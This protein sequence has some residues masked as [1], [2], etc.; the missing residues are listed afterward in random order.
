MPVLN[1]RELTMATA[2]DMKA[3]PVRKVSILCSAHP[4]WG[5]FGVM[6][7]KGDW[8]DIFGRGGWRV[9]FKDEAERFWEVKG[10]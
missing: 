9:L 3:L 7:D 10:N 8:Y 5:T 2:Y 4:E 1:E 6:E